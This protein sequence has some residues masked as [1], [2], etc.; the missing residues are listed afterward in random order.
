VIRARQ[1]QL[2]LFGCLGVLDLLGE[3]HLLEL[4]VSSAKARVDAG[5]E[6]ALRQ[7]LWHLPMSAAA[8]AT[9]VT[10]LVVGGG[11]SSKDA[12]SGGG[13]RAAGNDGFVCRG[14]DGIISVS[15]GKAVGRIWGSVSNDDGDGTAH[16]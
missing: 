16:I 12:G 13:G 1:E 14:V 4:G 2:L 9:G 6:G 8:S 7:V 11:T 5:G 10:S 3:P 15:A